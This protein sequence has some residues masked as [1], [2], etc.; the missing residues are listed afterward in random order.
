MDVEINSRVV[1]KVMDGCTYMYEISRLK[2]EGISWNDCGL[3]VECFSFASDSEI[4]SLYELIAVDS[5]FKP[6]KF[7]KKFAKNQSKIALLW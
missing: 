2:V 1:L 4:R 5:N 6:K 7:S 3:K